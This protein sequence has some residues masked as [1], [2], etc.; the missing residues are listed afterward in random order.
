[1]TPQRENPGQQKIV[2]AEVALK[3]DLIESTGTV[4][5]GR[6]MWGCIKSE[7]DMSSQVQRKLRP[8]SL[9]TISLAIRQ[10]IS[11]LKMATFL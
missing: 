10:K 2:S 1:M 9:L 11:K 4:K 7:V 6:Q 5:S 3:R 8:H